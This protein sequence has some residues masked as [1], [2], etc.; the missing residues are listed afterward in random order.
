M[1]GIRRAKLDCK[2]WKW[3]VLNVVGLLEA[4]FNI[5]ALGTFVVRWKSDVL[6]SDWME[7]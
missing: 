7:R 2:R 4:T 3:L 1:L 5:L 6:F